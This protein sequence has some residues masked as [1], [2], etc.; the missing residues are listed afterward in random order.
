[1]M[2]HCDDDAR[3]G[4]APVAGIATYVWY[5]E[6]PPS[7][8]QRRAASGMILAIV[9]ATRGIRHVPGWQRSGCDARRS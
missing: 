1:L 8:L 2:R 7:I 3:S 4:E 5:T 9:M 6:P